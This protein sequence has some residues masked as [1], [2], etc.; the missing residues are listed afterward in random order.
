MKTSTFEV[1]DRVITKYGPG[2]IIEIDSVFNERIAVEHDAANDKLYDC[3][4]LG[5]ECELR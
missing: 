2:T 3:S 4:I 5:G 1:G